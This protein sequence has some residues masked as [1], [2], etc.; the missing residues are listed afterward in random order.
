MSARLRALLVAALLAVTG[1]LTSHVGAVGPGVGVGMGHGL[2]AW[3]PCAAAPIYWLD[4]DRSPHTGTAP[5]TA[6]NDA[7]GSGRV[8]NTGTNKPSLSAPTLKGRS[9]LALAA[10]SQL[11]TT[12][13]GVTGAVPLTAYSVGRFTAIG[14]TTYGNLG[15]F[16]A[17]G[18]I[19]G[20]AYGSMVVGA[21]YANTW[22]GGGNNGVNAFPSGGVADTSDHI[23]TTDFDGTTA[24]VFVDGALIAAH[25][26]AFSLTSG[27][28]IAPWNNGGF[29]TTGRLYSAV[30]RSGQ[31]LPALRRRHV[32]YLA[33]RYGLT[34]A[35]VDAFVALGDSLTFGTGS[36]TPSTDSYPVQL[37]AAL[38]GWTY[39][40]TNTGAPGATAEQIA[41]D[42]TSGSVV[43]NAPIFA[44]TGAG[45]LNN[46]ALVYAGTND[47]FQ[48][49]ATATSTTWLAYM[50]TTLEA[51][52]YTVVFGTIF[53]WLSVP[54]A[55]HQTKADAI[56]AWILANVPA[57]HIVRFD[58]TPEM[59]LISGGTAYQATYRNASGGNAGHPTT[60]G[61]TAMAR[62]A[63]AVL[64]PLRQTSAPP[65]A[66]V[67]SLAAW[68]SRR[69]RRRQ[70]EDLLAL[71]GSAIKRRCA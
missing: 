42:G 24:R 44:S 53:P 27:Y 37:A 12:S 23:F 62:D 57:S 5:V 20:T 28:G 14:G 51:R 15:I 39:T 70:R 71:D 64:T 4:G 16:G 40:L 38:P 26:N 19:A 55:W 10:N 11:Y 66:P 25:A 35:R 41:N 56:N 8:L 9:G 43:A 49:I 65:L 18:A 1:L 17:T 50:K 32:Q 29:G 48:D 67:V 2:A 22:W 47:A 54:Q 45:W 6:L 3:T 63:A 33:T 68:V 58:L 30:W 59:A 61:Y 36:T 21:T 7:C 31:D 60:A 52:G 34:P 46:V 13:G 69:R